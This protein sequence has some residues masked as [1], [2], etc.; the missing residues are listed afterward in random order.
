MRS[1]IGIMFESA[2]ENEVELEEILYEALAEYEEIL[3]SD[4]KK[5]F[6]EISKKKEYKNVIEYLWSFCYDK[7]RTRIW[8]KR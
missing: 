5:E 8:V 3:I 7:Y 6:D 2:K 4:D 1:N